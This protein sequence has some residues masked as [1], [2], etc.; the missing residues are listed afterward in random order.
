MPD[1]PRGLRRQLEATIKTAREAAERGATDALTRLGVFDS[2][3]PAHLDDSRNA[4]RLR[5]R[6]HAKS[7]GDSLTGADG[8][9]L[10]RLVEAAA[11]IQWHRLLFS[12]FLL[13]RDLLRDALGVVSLADCRDEAGAG[14]DEWAVAAAHTARMLP[15]VFP[16][17]DPIE[18]LVLAPEH[19]KALRDLLLKLDSPTFQ[20]DDSLGWTYQFWRAAEKKAI[21][22]SQVKIGAAEFRAPVLPQHLNET[23]PAAHGVAPAMVAPWKDP[24]LPARLVDAICADL[25]SACFHPDLPTHFVVPTYSVQSPGFDRRRYWRG[26]VWLNTNWLLWHGLRQHGRQDL[27]HEIVRSS[28]GLV[29]LSG[30]REYFDPFDGTGRGSTDFSWS[31]AL[32]IDLI[33]SSTVR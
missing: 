29:A 32:A 3:R 18:A 2:R 25:E 27:A 19:A 23:P 26:P 6:A 20:A 11:Y 30:F 9:P 14:G 13:E 10:R 24:A 15:G 5:L 28:L 1:L 16:A 21:N 17:D 33:R 8:A 7:L 22:E 12:R 4:T 31:A